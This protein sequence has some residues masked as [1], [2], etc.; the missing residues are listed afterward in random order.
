MQIEAKTVE[1]AERRRLLGIETE[2]GFQMKQE[3]LS[4]AEG[5]E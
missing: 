4:L 2:S 5:L 1:S 3:N